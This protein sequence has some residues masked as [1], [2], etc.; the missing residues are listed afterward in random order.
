MKHCNDHL[1]KKY[2]CKQI[3]L[4]LLFLLLTIFPILAPQI[5]TAVHPFTVINSTTASVSF[6]SKV[7]G[8]KLAIYIF[9]FLCILAS[10]QTGYIILFSTGLWC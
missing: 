2:L 8:N 3:L 1:V 10:S 7:N 9:V 6:E 4:Q 5:E